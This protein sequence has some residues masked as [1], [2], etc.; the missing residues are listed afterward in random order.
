MGL[1]KVLMVVVLGLIMSGCIDNKEK[2]AF[3]T[4]KDFI[5][6]NDDGT[7]KLTDLKFYPDEKNSGSVT[8]G[9]VCATVIGSAKDGSKLSYP[10]Y[11]HVLLFGETKEVTDTRTV[12]SNDK[13]TSLDF[14]AKCSK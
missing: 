10:F 9:Y 14:I 4:V 3:Q 2:I 1:K 13:K 12:F 7:T 8:S 6:K 11:S 5:A